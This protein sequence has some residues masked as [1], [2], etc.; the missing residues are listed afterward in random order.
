MKKAI[1]G[2]IFSLCVTG[3]SFADFEFEF[4]FFGGL[5]NAAA[6]GITLQLGYLSPDIQE[7]EYGWGVLFDGGIGFRYGLWTF[8]S[9]YNDEGSLLYSVKEN[10]FYYHAGLIGEY[11]FLPFMGIALGGGIANGA[12]NGPVPY[13]RTEIPFLFEVVKVSLGFDYIFWN[14]ADTRSKGIILP[15]GYRINLSVR[16]RGV[17]A[18]ALLLGLF[19]PLNWAR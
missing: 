12:F 4:G 3:L 13:A 2:V 5:K 15:P 6:A 19:N 17:N 9:Y 10:L 14:N 8:N 1:L 7:A 11:Y 16:A 18:G